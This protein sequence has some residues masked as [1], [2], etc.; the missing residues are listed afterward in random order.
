MKKKYLYCATLLSILALSACSNQSDN[1]TTDSSTTTTTTSSEMTDSK[2]ET[3]EVTYTKEELETLDQF[4]S[5]LEKWL[6]ESAQANAYMEDNKIVIKIP[7]MSFSENSDEKILE[8]SETLLNYKQKIF[9]TYKITDKD[10]KEP[11]LIVKDGTDKTYA[12]ENEEH[13]MEISK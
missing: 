1:T 9:S 10:L 12:I 11:L 2:S 7:N 4:A 5:T 8:L 13:E 6:R 3:S